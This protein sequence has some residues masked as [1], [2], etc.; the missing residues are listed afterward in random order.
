[1]LAYDYPMLSFF[2]SLLMVFLFVAWILLLLRV[3]GDIFRRDSSGWAKALW[4]LFVILM[5]FLGT[6]VYLIAHGEGMIVRDV[7]VASE[8]QHAVD[9][10][11]RQV[12]GS[13]S[14]ADELEKL[15]SLRERGVL[16]DAEFTAQKARL[17]AT[18]G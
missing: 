1:M 7:E 6:L 3:F 2:W 11:I 4:S 17:L 8:Q 10:Y 12:A 18:A 5:P 15:A 9:S 14:T 13:H 16:S